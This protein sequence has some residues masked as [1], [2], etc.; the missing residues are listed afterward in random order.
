MYHLLVIWEIFRQNVISIREF[1]CLLCFDRISIGMSS[2]IA[3]LFQSSTQTHCEVANFA[4]S[5]SAAI[6]SFVPQKY[7]WQG[8][9]SLHICPRFVF[10]YLYQELYKSRIPNCN[11]SKTKT[12]IQLAGAFNFLE[13]LT[14]LGLTLVSSLEN[15]DIH[16][17]CFVTFGFSSLIYFILTYFIWTQTGFQIVTNDEIKSLRR[18]KAIIKIYV[19]LGIFMAFFYYRHN[20]Y[21]EPYVYSLFGLC[22]YC[23]VFANMAFHMTAYY[24]F[25]HLKFVIP[26]ISTP[27]DYLPVTN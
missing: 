25:A 19:M 20:E 17:V 6:G 9:V 18:K 10:L 26:S 24:D 23:V 7:V 27:K 11:S 16:K 12:L 4:P 8:C 2:F 22:E 15:F 3:S 13:L 1:L 14:L 5:I 21:C